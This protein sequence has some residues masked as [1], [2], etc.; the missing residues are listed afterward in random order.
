MSDNEAI[1]TLI[2]K[3]CLTLDDGDF[4][5]HLALCVQDYT[6]RIKVWSPELRKDM[7]W[8]EHDRDGL[9]GLFETLPEH[10]QR[11]GRLSRHVSTAAIEADSRTGAYIVVSNL[12]VHHTDLDGRTQVLAVGRYN[13]TVVQVDGAV[14]LSTREVVLETRDLGIGLHVPL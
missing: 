13:D 8:L 4:S 5:A 12:I 1:R 2:A 14:M 9:A 10:L 7:I 6:Y 3:S 11:S